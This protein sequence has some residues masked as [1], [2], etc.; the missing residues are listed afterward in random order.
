MPSFYVPIT[1]SR[2]KKALSTT[3]R[4]DR[5]FPLLIYTFLNTSMVINTC[6]LCHLLSDLHI[7]VTKTPHYMSPMVPHTHNYYTNP[8]FRQ[9]YTT[10]LVFLYIRLFITPSKLNTY[11]NS[12]PFLGQHKFTTPCGANLRNP[13]LHG[14]TVSGMQGPMLQKV[15]PY[16]YRND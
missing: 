12:H 10:L 9:S 15:R 14:Y 2:K 6:V 11:H 4:K 5:A 16:S 8:A 7:T 1:T 3:S 13:G